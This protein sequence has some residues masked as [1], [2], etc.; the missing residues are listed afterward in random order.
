MTMITPKGGLPG[1]LFV[2]SPSPGAFRPA[3]IHSVNGD[4][5]V[6][7]TDSTNN[8]MKSS[9]AFVDVGGTPPAGADYFQA[10]DCTS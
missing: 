3:Q 4:G 1:Q 2:K 5:T 7:V 9:I 10:I 6:N 8:N